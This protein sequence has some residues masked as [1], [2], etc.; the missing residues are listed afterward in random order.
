VFGVNGGVLDVVPAV[1]G[2][3]IGAVASA[4]LGL[5]ARH[6]LTHDDAHA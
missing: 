6:R 3:G 5:R 1:P 4:L 2:F